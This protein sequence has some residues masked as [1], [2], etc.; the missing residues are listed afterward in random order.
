MSFKELQKTL[1]GLD[2][3]IG[4]FESQLKELQSPP[5]NYKQ[6]AHTGPIKVSPPPF[7][8]PADNNT[9]HDFTTSFRNM[10][11]PK[12]Y[13][14]P[15]PRPV[16]FL[17]NRD[18]PELLDDQVS[19]CLSTGRDLLNE[20]RRS[21]LPKHTLT[22]STNTHMPGIAYSPM[23]NRSHL[24]YTGSIVTPSLNQTTYHRKKLLEDQKD[25]LSRS[26]VLTTSILHSIKDKPIK[27]PIKLNDDI[28]EDD[29]FLNTI[30][31]R[32][33]TLHF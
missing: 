30:R 3:K 20:I 21:I 12:Q 29:D 19:Q 32:N 31:M 16:P 11:P 27:K 9:Q 17:S 14:K 15:A 22:S 2:D 33:S 1:A 28:D 23:S 5:K 4:F 26:S 18:N 8:M 25:I 10:S 13:K 7:Q 24:T 6:P